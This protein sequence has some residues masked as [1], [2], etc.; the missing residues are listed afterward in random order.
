M[1]RDRRL[2]FLAVGHFL[3][4]VVTGLLARVELGD[5][6]GLA[7]VLPPFG[8][9][10]VLIV[11]LFASALCQAFLL[12]MWATYSGASTWGRMAGLLAGSVYLEALFPEALRLEFIGGSSVAVVVTAVILFVARRRGVILIHQDEDLQ[13]TRVERDGL[14]FS[15]R[16]LMLFTAVVAVLSAGARALYQYRQH[17]LLLAILWSLCFV[18]VG[19]VAL[20]AVMGN[21]RPARRGPVVFALAPLLGVFFAVAAHA[22]ASGW[23]L[24]CLT[25]LGYP[26]LLFGSLLVVRL[27]GFRLVRPAL[28]RQ[29]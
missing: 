18:T 26:S 11:P 20:W 9:K 12:A 5:P 3:L 28:N 15:I 21:A 10:H 22:H 7:P 25:M 29:R 27:C 19:L 23:F 2:V 8:L 13:Q 16:G 6:F 14:Q 24:I 17:V 4:G 1:R